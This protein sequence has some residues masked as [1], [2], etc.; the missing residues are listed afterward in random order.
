MIEVKI[1]EPLAP[2]RTIEVSLGDGI[3]ATDGAR[4]MPHT[5]RFTTGGG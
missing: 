4:L 3:L 2:Y 5:L 1:A